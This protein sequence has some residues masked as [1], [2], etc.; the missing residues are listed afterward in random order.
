MAT[1]TEVGKK[2]KADEKEAPKAVPSKEPKAP[3]GSQT[4]TGNDA[5]KESKPPSK[6]DGQ[7]QSYEDLAKEVERLKLENSAMAKDL[8]EVKAERDALKEEVS[9]VRDALAVRLN[10]K[11]GEELGT[12]ANAANQPTKLASLAGVADPNKVKVQTSPTGTGR[13]QGDY[14]SVVN[15][16]GEKARF[17]KVTWEKIRKGKTTWKEDKEPKE[18]RELKNQRNGKND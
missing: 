4:Q 17:S 7:I 12:E 1:K 9:D 10:A 14:V 6:E 3:E 8:E 15:S 18:V 2:G 16:K 13:S 5:G 11:P